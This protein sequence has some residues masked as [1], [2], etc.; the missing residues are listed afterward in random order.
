MVQEADAAVAPSRFHAGAG[1]TRAN[2]R[3]ARGRSL[4]IELFFV[5]VLCFVCRRRSAISGR[6]KSPRN[7]KMSPYAI[8]IAETL[9]EPLEWRRVAGS[10]HATVTINESDV[11]LGHFNILH[12]VFRSG[13]QK[14]SFSVLTA[15][16]RLTLFPTY[17]WGVISE[18]VVLLRDTG[19][20]A[21]Q[22]DF[23]AVASLPRHHNSRPSR[24]LKVE[25][26]RQVYVQEEGTT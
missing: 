2:L 12:F 20:V 26:T 23:D 8:Y 7:P 13:S 21:L 9:Q 5:C 6:L 17:V 16:Q 14:E 4:S 3:T 22:R 1:R 15:R 19:S 10:R 25:D 18:G 24:S 11:R